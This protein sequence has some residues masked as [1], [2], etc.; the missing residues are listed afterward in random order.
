MSD[1]VK[2]L[3]IDDEASV[4][5]VLNEV[6][7]SE[8][9]RVTEAASAEDAL[10]ALG[11]EGYD[12]LISDIRL[13]GLSGMQLLQRVKGMGIPSEVIIMTSYASFETSLEAIR[14]GAYD[15][16]VKPFDQI[17]HV[18]NVV[19]RAVERFRFATE[20]EVLVT[21]LKDKNERLL[22]ATRRAARILAE[23][24]TNRSIVERVLLARDLEETGMRIAEGTARLFQARSSAV[25]ILDE[26]NRLLR[27]VGR[28]GIGPED[29]SSI[30]LPFSD[31]REIRLKVAQ[32]MEEGGHR[33]YVV[34][35][36][37]K[38]GGSL[39]WYRPLCTP[40]GGLGLIVCS[41]SDPS[42]PPNGDNP[43]EKV[44][45]LFF[46]I[47]THALRLHLILNDHSASRKGTSPSRSDAF[48]I[49]DPVTPFY[50][51]EMFEEL[52][53]LEIRRCKRYMHHFTVLLLSLNIP[54]QHSDPYLLIKELSYLLQPRLRSTDMATRYGEKFF[55]LMVG[56]E[57]EEA[58]KV[59]ERLNELLGGYRDAHRMDETRSRFDWTIAL[60]DYPKD[61]DTVEGLIATLETLSHQEASHRQ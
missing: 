44:A 55:L 41:E 22:D 16:L 50:S 7:S 23:S 13:P 34:E 45:D 5:G 51:F 33:E 19:R 58:R 61:A 18:A 52:I 31:N 9:Y 56:T 17:E 48:V 59:K 54:P 30:S 4:R 1:Q 35:L 26:G 15:Y 10:T 3:V 43:E 6:L 25:W 46:L 8:G 47:S 53:N 11:S 28:F 29:L 24:H 27:P 37:K 32:W 20:N 21:G 60:V 49:H 42:A 38:W 14:L 2:I 36:G 12:V 57:M 39:L 40:E